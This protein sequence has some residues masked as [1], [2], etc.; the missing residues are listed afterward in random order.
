MLF[1][2]LLSE[3]EPPSRYQR[4]LRGAAVLRRLD[5]QGLAF[6]AHDHGRAPC[7]LISSNGWLRDQEVDLGEHRRIDRSRTAQRRGVAKHVDEAEMRAERGDEGVNLPERKTHDDVDV[8]GRRGI[9]VERAA[10]LP[11]TKYVPASRPR[12]IAAARA[13]LSRW[14]RPPSR[15]SKLHVGEQPP[16]GHPVE[17]R[18]DFA[19]S[20]RARW[21]RGRRCG[22][23]AP[24]AVS[25]MPTSPAA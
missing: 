19:R 15:S 22:R 10:T 17:P 25:P 24:R 23:R 11:P 8:V 4:S 1:A 3:T 7:E 6:F 12:S 5:E 20:P 18:G 2:P 9:T 21:P 14:D 16:G 13:G